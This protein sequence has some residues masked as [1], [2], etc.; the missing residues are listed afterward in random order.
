MT[1]QQKKVSLTRQFYD[2]LKYMVTVAVVYIHIFVTLPTVSIRS[3]AGL[4]PTLGTQIS[5]S[6]LLSNGSPAN[7]KTLS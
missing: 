3:G 5:I 2:S 7:L 4:V 1:H 6:R